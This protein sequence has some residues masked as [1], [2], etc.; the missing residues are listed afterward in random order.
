MTMV[1]LSGAGWQLEQIAGVLFDKDGTLVDSHRYWG[2]II[3]RRAA[4]LVRRYS[5]DGAKNATLMRVMGFDGRRLLPEGPIA[6]VS[7]DEVISIVV[8]HLQQQGVS[9]TKMD[10]AQIFIDEHE[11]FVDELPHYIC[12][13]QGVHAFCQS[14][15]E[16]EVKL[17]VV[18]TDTVVNTELTLRLLGLDDCFSAIIG[19]ESTI[20]SKT[21][22]E[23]ALAALQQLRL[24]GSTVVAVGDAP[25]DLI[26]AQKS[27]L[28]AGIG[29]TSGQLG[30]EVLA[31]YSDYLVTSLTEIKIDRL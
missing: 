3:E 9:A 26:M 29:V 16:A 15:R 25:M 30:R 4:A 10:V 20:G 21:T 7:R 23:P 22:G 13:L 8:Q 28:L 19:K 5:L 24:P 17:A 18:T 31:T 12:A 1:R 14:L 6:L 27:S 11:A 2:R